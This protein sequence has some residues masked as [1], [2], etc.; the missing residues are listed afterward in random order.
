MGVTDSQ[1][2]GLWWPWLVV[3]ILT[4]V[5]FAVLLRYAL[6][7]LLPSRRRR[8]RGGRTVLG[9]CLYL[10][11]K[12]VMDIYEV[13]GFSESL[14]EEVA[15][16]INVTRNIGL[17]GKLFFWN[18]HADQ[19]ITK[20][21]VTTY[22]RESTPMNV[23]GVLMDTM[24]K[25]DVVVDADLIT[26]RLVLNRSLSES[27]RDLDD[28]Q[29]PLSAFVSEWVSVTGRFTARRKDNGDVEL[30]ARYGDGDACVRVTCVSEEEQ[31]E[32]RDEEYYT[33]EFPARC[34]GRVR[35]WESETSELLLDPVAIFR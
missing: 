2:W 21:R 12:R 19:G 9:I 15:D 32:L 16:R 17:L 8:R 25:E 33:G 20:E 6:L 29:V 24:R 30:R 13:G 4:A 7:R 3:W 14:A 26:G 35:R 28:G 34:L 1:W 27:L 10:H 11:K 5:C 23:I 18:A 22:L 31:E